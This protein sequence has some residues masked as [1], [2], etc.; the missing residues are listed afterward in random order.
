MP[1]VDITLINPHPI[2]DS[3]FYTG[4]LLPPLGLAFLAAVL[5]KNGYEVRIIDNYLHRASVKECVKEV[6]KQSPFLVGLTCT[7]ITYQPCIELAKEIKNRLEVPIVVGG[8]HPTVLPESML[9]HPFIDY[10]VIGEGEYTLLELATKIEKGEDPKKV[11]G[12]MYGEGNKCVFTGHREFIKNLDSLPHPARDLLPMSL[13]PNRTE[14]CSSFPVL[15]INSSRGCPFG[16]RFCSVS[17]IW[18]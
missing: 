17:S 5:R 15:S 7:S 6:V 11:K 18:G 10:V 1:D 13:Y 16:C 8:P 2:K 4:E 3:P 12:L 14:F 9:Q